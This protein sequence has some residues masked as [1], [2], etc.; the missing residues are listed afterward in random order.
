MDNVCRIVV[1]T[2]TYNEKG[3]LSEF[4][5]KVLALDC[6]SLGLVIVDDN[7]PDGTGDLADQFA[8]KHP[9]L[10]SVIHRPTKLGLRSAYKCGFQYAMESG[11][12]I[13]IQ[14][15][16]DLSHS[17]ED[18]PGLVRK[19]DSADVVI[20]SRYI[21][22]G[23]L[24]DSW[25]FLRKYLSYLGNLYIRLI[26]GIDVH[27][28]TSGFKAFRRAVL[29]KVDFSTFRCYGFGF[30]AEFTRACLELGFVVIEQP[31]IFKDRIHGASKI[32]CGIVFEAL[33]KIPIHRIQRIKL[34]LF[35]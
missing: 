1:V 6:H 3:N 23:G 24:D 33:W 20:G 32:S 22:D 35:E 13:I 4:I 8:T 19:L 15:D 30:Q 31:I 16:T 29:D 2:P 27:D 17:P 34:N 7:S 28:G 14:M 10:I 12:E 9:Q 11:A 5:E 18:I 21:K 25:S 26:G